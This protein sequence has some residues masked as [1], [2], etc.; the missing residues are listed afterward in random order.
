MSNDRILVVDHESKWVSLLRQIL[1]DAGFSV[2]VTHK[3]ER[4]IQLSAEDP[5][6][7]IVTELD[8]PGSISGLDLIRR[9]RTFSELP[10]VIL[11]ARAETSD[12]LAGF[13]AGADDYIVKPY[14][15]RILLA[16]IRAVLN[17]CQSNVTAPAKITCNNLVIN[18]TA[19]QVALN[20]T[21]IYLT[22]T[23]Y[24]LLLELAKHADQVMLHE[25]LLLAVWGPKFRQETEYLRSYV[26]ILR[27]KLENDPSQPALIISRPGIGY[28]LVSSAPQVSG[29]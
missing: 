19:R 8:L 12:M 23:E 5:P 3:G 13:E 29:T 6:G 2:V 16:R 27:R 17:R 10:V 21:P 24:N 7:L 25:Q 22:E 15:A 26:H 4:A 20:G 14:D 18:Q 1:T 11:S 28:M 9:I